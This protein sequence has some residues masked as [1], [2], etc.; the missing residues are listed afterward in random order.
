MFLGDRLRVAFICYGARRTR[1][2]SD[3]RWS[4]VWIESYALLFYMVGTSIYYGPG[5][6]FMYKADFF[7]SGFYYVGLFL[8]RPMLIDNSRPLYAE[9]RK[10]SF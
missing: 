10:T 2:D 3:T 6:M 9:K 7:C 5:V 4:A 8:L 1:M